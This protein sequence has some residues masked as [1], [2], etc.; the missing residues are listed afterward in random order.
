MQEFINE[1][2]TSFKKEIIEV[3]ESNLNDFNNVEK[4]ISISRRH[5]QKLRLCLRKHSFCSP[6]Q[7]IKFFKKQ[8]P[9]VYG[10]LKFYAKWYYYLL[11][12]P[13]GSIKLQ[14]NFIDNQ[15]S[16][17]QENNLCIIDFIKYYRES[18]TTLDEFYF[19]RGK[20][21]ISLVSDT[22]HFYTDAEFSTSHDNA[23]AKLIAYD[24]LIN[25]YTLELSH[26]RDLSLGKPKR[27]AGLNHMERL[28]WTASKTDLIELIYALQASGAIRGGM[29]GIK[30]MASACEYMFNIELGN[31]YRTFLEIRERKIDR[32]KFV[33][34]LKTTLLNRMDE[35]DE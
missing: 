26:L 24:L 29:A 35:A 23:V 22:S 9:F 27:I 7:E 12:K 3:E 21:N 34:R 32:T 1:I 31:V 2:L 13:E 4:G 18:S 15:I 8:K 10:R 17:L 6:E 14:R 20:D 16:K 30:E 11:Q 33:D 25:R 28:S 19:L 5:L